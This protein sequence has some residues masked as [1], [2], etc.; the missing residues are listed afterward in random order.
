LLSCFSDQI[1]FTHLLREKKKK[2]YIC[3]IMANRS[4][5]LGSSS[6]YR[7]QY[8]KAVKLFDEDNFEECIEAAR[9]NLTNNALP[10]YYRMKNLLLIAGAEE[11]RYPAE[12]CRLQAEQIWYV[13]SL[14]EKKTH[15]AERGPSCVAAEPNIGHR[16]SLR[17]ACLRLTFVGTM[18]TA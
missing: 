14:V 13:C 4:D 18:P 17:V 16:S 2:P 10:H 1:S 12:R 11:D 7:T 5:I 8:L 6:L 9:Y 15:G 3:F